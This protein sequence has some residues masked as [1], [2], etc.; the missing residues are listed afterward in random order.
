M[1]VIFIGL[2]IFVA[3]ILEV[4]VLLA[5][6]EHE[7]YQMFFGTVASRRLYRVLLFRVVGADILVDD[8]IDATSPFVGMCCLD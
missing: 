8:V 6:H 4:W 3:S 2:Q 7:S 5:V 1:H